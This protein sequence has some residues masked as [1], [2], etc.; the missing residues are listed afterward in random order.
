M[1]VPQTQMNGK[2]RTWLSYQP[3]CFFSCFILSSNM[4]SD[5]ISTSGNI[6]IWVLVGF[7]S[8]LLLW[9]VCALVS[10]LSQFEHKDTRAYGW[11][12]R[13]LV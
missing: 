5:C 10:L 2:E 9:G 8:L 4:K 11:S 3:L 12:S 7:F 13:I 6:R 1:C